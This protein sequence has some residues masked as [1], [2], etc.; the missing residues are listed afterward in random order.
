MEQQKKIATESPLLLFHSIDTEGQTWVAHVPAFAFKFGGGHELLF[1]TVFRHFFPGLSIFRIRFLYWT[2]LIYLLAVC[3]SVCLTRLP[4]CTVYCVGLGY[5]LFTIALVHVM[6]FSI[7]GF[8]QVFHPGTKIL[9]SLVPRCRVVIWEI[10]PDQWFTGK[11]PV[12]FLL[13]VKLGK[14]QLKGK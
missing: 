14:N 5:S 9:S 4:F 12:N 6:G 3:L 7:L 8:F 11:W 13:P 10:L 2:L 1:W